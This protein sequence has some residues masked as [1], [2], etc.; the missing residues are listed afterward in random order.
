MHSVSEKTVTA[1]LLAGRLPDAFK[2]SSG[3][4]RIPLSSAQGMPRSRHLTRDPGWKVCST[5]G[6][7][8]PTTHFYRKRK[9]AL[10]LQNAC[11]PC[12]RA[13]AAQWRAEHPYYSAQVSSTGYFRTTVRWRRI[14]ERYGLT[15]DDV[16]AMEEAQEHRCGICGV[17]KRLVID[18]CHSTGRVR[19]LLCNQCNT[20]LGLLEKPDWLES[21]LGYLAEHPAANALGESVDA[22]RELG[23]QRSLIRTSRF[24]GVCWDASRQKWMAKIK[25]AGRTKNLGRFDEEEEAAG[26]YREALTLLQKESA[27]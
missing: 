1:W 23:R 16:H 25:V 12:Q 5:C 18:H 14:L 22:L 7:R 6:E 19:G 10:G 11:K 21:A 20:F 4:W 13:R 2:A 17:E 27:A 26:A 15:E 3:A 8:K 9:G 24:A